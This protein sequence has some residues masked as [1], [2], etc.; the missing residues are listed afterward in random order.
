[1]RERSWKR[2]L[3]KMILLLSLH[4]KKQWQRA[5]GTETMEK[6]RAAWQNK[7]ENNVGGELSRTDLVLDLNTGSGLLTL[8]AARC[9]LMAV[10]GLL[11]MIRNHFQQ[12]PS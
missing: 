12:C 4:L 9:T 8:E 5:V 10:Y 2:F 3:M 1:M 6:C 7:R 11:C